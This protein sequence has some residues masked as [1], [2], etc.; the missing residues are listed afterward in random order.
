MIG[1]DAIPT[2]TNQGVTDVD[3]ESDQDKEVEERG[4]A[5]AED[6]TYQQPLRTSK[7]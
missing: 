7:P 1:I 2:S 3:E 4:H 6:D 5:A